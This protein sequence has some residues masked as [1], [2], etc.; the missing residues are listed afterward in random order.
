MKFE[1]ASGILLHPTSLPSRYG[2]GDL[3]PQAYQWVDFLVRSG[4]SLWQI[5]PL[6]PTGYGDSPYQCFSAF[7]GNP[8]LISPE[9]LVSEGLL[10]VEDLHGE[11]DY[12]PGWVD[13]GRL[14]PRK[15]S[16]LDRAFA[17][18]EQAAPDSL[19]QEYAAFKEQQSGWLDDF[20][21]F[22]ALKNANHGLPWTKWQPALRDR[23][24]AALKSARQQYA[25]EVERQAF[26][27]FLFSRQWS[28]LRAYAASH[29]LKTI[30]DIPIFVAHDSADVW[31]HPEY[32]FLNKSGNPTV[33]AGVPPDYF[34]KTGQLW[35]NPLYRWKAHAADGFSWW[36]NRFR[37][38]LQQVDIVRLD[39]FRGFAGY[40]EVPGKAPTAETGRWRSGPGKKI[41]SALKNALSDLPIIAEDLGVITPDVIDLR[42]SFELPG[43]KV[44]VFAFAGDPDDPFLP[45]NYTRNCVVYTG[46]HDNDTAV[47]WYRR[48]G[49]SERSFYRKYLNQD[50]SNVAWDLIRA[51][52][53]SVAVFALAPLQDFLGLGNEARMNYPGNPSG[54]WN[55]R[56]T[57]GALTDELA[58]SIRE[59]NDLYSRDLSTRDSDQNRT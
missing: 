21:L 48:V 17:R 27:Q 56:M 49:E 38:V 20:S 12:Q 5:L 3:G 45:H 31:A 2:I 57:T 8:Y 24:T 33:V 59:L 32:F 19:M 14:I 13:Y 15:L 37:A 6:G 47:G 34:S 35:G 26:R 4:C 22:M 53:A 40:W 41:F 10:L 1:R 54:N 52:W 46:T 7:A 58:E 36:I 51:C 30:G 11:A 50:G 55:W 18:F 42:D 43:M 39:H 23:E 16:I 44:L 25:Q 28:S 29:K 9:L